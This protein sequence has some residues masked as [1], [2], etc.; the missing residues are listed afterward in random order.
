M[1]L[2]CCYVLLL[3][4]TY[5]N[6]KVIGI[7]TNSDYFTWSEAN[8]YCLNTFGTELAN[9]DTVINWNNSRGVY[10]ALCV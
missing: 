8:D 4:T 6:S 10:K 7:I 3:D 9:V 1:L 5:E 2:C